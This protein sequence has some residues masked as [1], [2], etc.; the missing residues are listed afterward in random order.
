MPIFSDLIAGTLN[1]IYINN[2]R[3]KATTATK[4]WFHG[5]IKSNWISFFAEEKNCVTHSL[6]WIC[7]R[8]RFFS[9]PSFT[10]FFSLVSVCV[11]VCK[12][13]VLSKNWLKG[14][15]KNV[16]LHNVPMLFT[17]RTKYVYIVS[18][19]SERFLF[20]YKTISIQRTFYGC[21]S[22]SHTLKCHIKC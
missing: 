18:C 17:I 12:L 19:M 9:F 20:N 13:F 10:R 3:Q 2:C 4:K 22:Y 8:K 5:I 15:R 7:D 16:K 11:C 14:K 6:C 1:L 21:A